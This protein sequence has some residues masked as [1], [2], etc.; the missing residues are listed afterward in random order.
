MDDSAILCDEV[1]DADAD[2]KTKSNDE[3]KSNDKA[4]SY[5]KTNFNEKKTIYKTENF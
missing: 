2:A 1:L 5:G 4:K 3:A